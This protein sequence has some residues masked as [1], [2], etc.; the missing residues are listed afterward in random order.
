MLDVGENPN[1]ENTFPHTLP[2]SFTNSDNKLMQETKRTKVG[3]V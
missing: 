2:S 1:K 3:N